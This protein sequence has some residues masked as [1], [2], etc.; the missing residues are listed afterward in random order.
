[1]MWLNLM[2][3]E[4]ESINAR[5]GYKGR[6]R[7]KDVGGGTAE[8]KCRWCGSKNVIKYG[9]KGGRQQYKC[10]ECGRQ[11]IEKPRYKRMR[12]EDLKIAMKMRDEGMSYAAI[13][14]VLGYAESTIRKHIKK[15]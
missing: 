14:R 8:L 10:K 9:K 7:S 6:K 2:L 13:G 15:T 4:L 12:E 1:M 11:M 5:M 3:A